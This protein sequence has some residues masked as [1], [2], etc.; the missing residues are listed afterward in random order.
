M[1]NG[2]RSAFTMIEVLISIALLGLLLTGLYSMLEQERESNKKLYEYLQKSSK[3]DKVV[4]AL[5]NDI[6]QSDGNIT[7]K[8][9]EFDN[10]C[11]ESTK[12]SLYALGEAKV[13]WIV[14][15]EVNRLIR[16]EGNGYTLPLKSESSVSADRVMEN[17]KTF[18]V[19]YGKKGVIVAVLQ[20]E[21]REPY[22]FAVYGIKPPEFPK[23]KRRRVKHKRESNIPKIDKNPHRE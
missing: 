21:G 7:I 3:T 9:S 5:Y 22:S 6:L 2:G 8:R 16:I 17:I 14:A 19:E 11:I 1:V 15:K 13:C 18:R 20:K 12:N 4:T 23:K 10:L